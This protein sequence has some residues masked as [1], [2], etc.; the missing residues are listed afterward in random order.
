MK[1][2]MRKSA[3]KTPQAKPEPTRPPFRDGPSARAAALRRPAIVDNRPQANAQRKLQAMADRSPQVRRLAQLQDMAK[4]S[5][6]VKAKVELQQLAG[7]FSQ[8]LQRQEALEEDEE[9]QFRAGPGT[10]RRQ[11]LEEE[12][13]PQGKMAPV[14]RQEEL[15]EEELLQGQFDPVQREIPEDE[16]LLQGQFANGDTPAQR[17]GVEDAVENRTGMPDPLKGGLEQLSGLDLSGLRVHCNSAKPAQLNALAYAQGQDIHLGPGQEQHLPHEGWHAVQQMQGRVKPTMQAKG[18][19]INDDEGL[20]HEADVMGAR[21]L[22]V[23]SSEESAFEFPIHTDQSEKVIGTAAKQDR[24]VIQRNIRAHHSFPD[25]GT[26]EIDM[27]PSTS[28]AGTALYGEEG[29]IRFIPL[30][31]GE[32][33]EKITL[34]Q[35]VEVTQNGQDKTWADDE[36]IREAWK[37]NDGRFIDVSGADLSKSPL[38]VGVPVSKAYNAIN[39]NLAASGERITV[40]NRRHG[41]D[42]EIGGPRLVDVSPGY[43][44]GEKNSKWTELW[45]HPSFADPVTCSFE[46]EVVAE[47]EVGQNER[48]WGSVEWG[49]TTTKAVDDLQNPIWGVA[50]ERCEFRDAPTASHIAAKTRFDAVMGNTGSLSAQSIES[51]KRLF[52]NPE[53]RDQGRIEIEAIQQNVDEYIQTLPVDDPGRTWREKLTETKTTLDEFMTNVVEEHRLFRTAGEADEGVEASEEVGDERT[54]LLW[55]EALVGEWQ[56][57]AGMAPFEEVED[58]EGSVDQVDPTFAGMQPEDRHK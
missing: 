18:V 55:K 9:L 14:Q 11:D 10:I 28:A 31:S 41:L 13:L 40:G 37:A 45:D 15:E 20:E 46:T 48:S 12:E 54:E 30:A 52:S 53:T 42:K 27:A 1:A 38:G 16:E 17:Q 24:R 26:L 22:Q 58:S 4:I 44:R 2:V 39:A 36:A 56:E 34:I 23:G 5:P 43:N 6:R 7:G 47:D 3:T 25:Y 51:A 21:A 29:V 35:S 49:F 8:P 57:L 33:A 32:R 50:N 19:P